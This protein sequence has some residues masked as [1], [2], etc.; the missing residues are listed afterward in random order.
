[1][2]TF[3]EA[4]MR[5]LEDVA[6][7][8]SADA[9]AMHIDQ[10]LPFIGHLPLEHVH[11]DTVKPFVDHEPSAGCHRR[12][13]TTHRHHRDGAEASRRASGAPRKGFPGCA[14]RPRS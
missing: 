1:V 12:R 9:I 8:S 4:A 11:D 2:F 6:E 7:K 10:M 3:E 5:Y 13:S 14:R